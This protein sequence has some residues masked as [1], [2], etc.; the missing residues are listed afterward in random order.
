MEKKPM[1][2][3]TPEGIG[4]GTPLTDIQEYNR[5]LKINNAVLGLIM[6]AIW[7]GV[8]V[9]L[10]LIWYIMDKNVLNNIVASCV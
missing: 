7:S 4:E 2:I 8:L 5:Q 10:W 3:S 6:G 9:L 1:Q